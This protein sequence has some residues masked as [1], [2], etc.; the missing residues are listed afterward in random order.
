M[1]RLEKI[2]ESMDLVVYETSNL[3]LNGC[4]IHHRRVI[5]LRYNTDPV[6]KRCALAHELGHAYYGDEGPCEPRLERRADLF[7]ADLLITKEAYAE[8]ERI[9]PATSFIAQELSVTPHLVEVWKQHHH[10]WSYL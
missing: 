3:P 5:L 8:A 9:H 4:Y 10:E 2:A 7:A 1:D 6:T